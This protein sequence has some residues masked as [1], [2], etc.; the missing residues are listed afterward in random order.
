MAVEGLS[1]GAIRTLDQERTLVASNTT[2]NNIGSIVTQE[3]DQGELVEVQLLNFTPFLFN[4]PALPDT[5]EARNNLSRQITTQINRFVKGG[6]IEAAE[7]PTLTLW[8]GDV[9]FAAFAQNNLFLRWAAKTADV[10]FEGQFLQMLSEIQIDVSPTGAPAVLDP[11]PDWDIEEIN[12]Y[13]YTNRGADII[14]REIEQQEGFFEQ[15]LELLQNLGGGI[16]RTLSSN[17][18]GIPTIFLIA[19]GVVIIPEITKTLREFNPRE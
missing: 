16:G 13:R 11:I 3:F 12:V 6:T 2:L 10:D 5:I 7:F 1:I 17:V 15:L 9:P 8:P 14:N 19:A 4:Q 18:G